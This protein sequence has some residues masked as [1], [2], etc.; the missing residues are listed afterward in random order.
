M[1]FIDVLWVE[2]WVKT[3]TCAD[4]SP[5]PTAKMLMERILLFMLLVVYLGTLLGYWSALNLLFTITSVLLVPL[6]GIYE[7][8][9]ESLGFIKEG[10]FWPSTFQG[11]AVALYVTGAFCQS[12]VFWTLL[13]LLF[14]YF[15][16]YGQ[17]NCKS[18]KGNSPLMRYKITF[19]WLCGA[20]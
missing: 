18:V 5:P 2:R 14:A 13:S 19:V 8:N 9:K 3:E 6:V 7:G 10:C 4:Y 12:L 11:G 1:C 20:L 17:C 16:P 15:A